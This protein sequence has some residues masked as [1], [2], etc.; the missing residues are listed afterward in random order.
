[1]PKPESLN[2]LAL[3]VLLMSSPLHVFALIEIGGGDTAEVLSE[4]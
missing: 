4:V 1:M 3:P 2:S